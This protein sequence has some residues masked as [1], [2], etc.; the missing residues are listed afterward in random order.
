MRSQGGL[1][2]NLDLLAPLKRAVL[3]RELVSQKTSS[4]MVEAAEGDLGGVGLRCTFEER[5]EL[6]AGER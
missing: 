1:H 3:D 5:D 4:R 6:R 2:T